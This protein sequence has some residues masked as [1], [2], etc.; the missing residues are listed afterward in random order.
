MI[1]QAL[2]TLQTRIQQRCFAVHIWS[3]MVLTQAGSAQ[4]ETLA[5]ADLYN[6]LM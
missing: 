5:P 1:A 3:Q 6:I 2:H 4:T